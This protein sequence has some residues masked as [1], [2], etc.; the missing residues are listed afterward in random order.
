MCRFYRMVR[1]GYK[2]PRGGGIMSHEH[3]RRYNRTKSSVE[4]LSFIKVFMCNLSHGFINPIWQAIRNNRCYG[5]RHDASAIH[6]YR[7]NCLNGP[8]SEVVR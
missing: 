2:T 1:E 5:K 8:F 7:I 3:M 4:N 6:W